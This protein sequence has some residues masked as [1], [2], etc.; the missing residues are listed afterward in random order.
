MFIE[1]AKIDQMTKC[2]FEGETYHLNQRFYP[3]NAEC[4]H[5]LCLEGFNNGTA[6]EENS[7]CEKIDCGM[8]VRHLNDIRNGCVP[9]YYE[10]GCCPIEIKCRK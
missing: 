1:Q 4:Y 6:V 9:V 8:E 5:C 10:S 3:K 7:C 2:H